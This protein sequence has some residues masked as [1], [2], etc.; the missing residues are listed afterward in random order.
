[1]ALSI[2]ARSVTNGK[3]DFNVVNH[4]DLFSII[5]FIGQPQLEDVR[6]VG[7]A[8]GQRR[9][10]LL[11][12]EHL[13]PLRELQVGR[14]DQAA[15]CRGERMKIEMAHIERMAASCG[16]EIATAGR[17]GARDFPPHS[18]QVCQPDRGAPLPAPEAR[19]AAC[20]DS[21]VPA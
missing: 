6:L 12:A 8:V 1:M 11:V 19:R 17:Q 13:R 20:S 7:D 4:D 16:R 18:G 9:R 21:R 5:A 2:P 10:H 14:Y 3:Y 15:A